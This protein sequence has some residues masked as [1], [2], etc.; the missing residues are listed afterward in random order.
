MKRIRKP[1]SVLFAV[2]L[3]TSLSVSSFAAG[4][5]T[6]D[7]TTGT[8]WPDIDLDGVVT[9][10]TKTD[11]KDNYA[12]YV[13]KGK[14][15]NLK[16]PEGYSYAGSWMDL[17]LLAAQN[18]RNMFL[19]DAPEGHDARLA[20]DLFR[21]MM[22]WDSRNALGITPLKK[23]T[24]A[25]EAIDTLDAL[26]A[27]FCEVP[28]EDQLG[29]V[30][31]ISSEAD[32]DDS[33][34]RILM[35]SECDLLLQNSAEYENLTA[36]GEVRK[37]AFSA[38]A[39]KMLVRLGYSE[40]EARKKIDNCFAYEGMVAPAIYTNEERG[41]SDYPARI[42]NHMSCKELLNAEGKLPI[43]EQLEKIG[44]PEA[45]SYLIINPGFFAQLNKVHTEENLPLIRDYIIVHGVIRMAKDL[46]RQCYEW[47][48]E[49]KNMISGS[50]GILDDATAFSSSVSDMLP[51]PV[52]Q[53]YTQTYLKQED[54][55]RIAA[56]IDQI[57]EAYHG[58]L[59]EADFL[60]EET[61]AKA[62]EKL[63]A[64]RP[65][66]LYPDSWEKYDCGD[67]NYAGP[68]DGGTLADAARAITR[69]NYEKMVKEFSEPIDKEEWFTTPQTVNCFYNLQDNSIF[70]LGARAQGNLYNSNM[71]DEELYG[72]LGTAIG[73]EISH[74]FDR[75][76]AQF[77]KDG[78]MNMWWTEED[79]EKFQQRNARLEAYY[80][81]MHPWEG[82][83]FY[84]SIMTGEACA[85][86]AGMKVMLKIAAEKDNFDY[87][88][89]FR[90][91]AEV[92]L[93]RETLQMAYLR[94]N[95]S[96]PMCYLRINCT[97][98][99]FDE[100]LNYYGITEGD[101]MYLAPED[102]VAIW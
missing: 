7:Y 83:D 30:W 36:Y 20:Y 44:F 56:M 52:A 41:R 87:D 26:N 34:K 84:G 39:A 11:L 35:L 59:A 43:L 97:M 45:E 19:G 12:L 42:N 50:T 2:L 69:Y 47:N 93:T 78:N 60:S 80:N 6:P 22:D 91:F 71:S 37:T 95:D 101:R 28:P 13:N 98:Q 24:D 100:F 53:L 54:K 51:W 77:G 90:A 66:V 82:Q 10:D 31:N 79:Y 86:M 14:I 76:G 58:I 49:C 89:F 96:H 32:L 92:W 17:K 55:D 61:K 18:L 73:H 15:L 68:E 4:A 27:Y 16:I 40:D 72:K 5:Q 1:V 48:N 67:L 33:S 8:P 102:R 85:D 38:L 81:A 23:M 46:D 74:A 25:V 62:I 88:A 29:S 99:Q 9:E 3:S 63:E 64:I 70:I 65:K 57:K 21:L 94:I 75:N